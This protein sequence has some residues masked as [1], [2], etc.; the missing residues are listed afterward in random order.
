[1]KKET[2]EKICIDVTNCA[3]CGENH[4]NIEFIRFKRNQIDECEFWGMCPKLNEPILMS[5][6]NYMALGE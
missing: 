6:E 2:I 1:M 3:R 4:S 5:L